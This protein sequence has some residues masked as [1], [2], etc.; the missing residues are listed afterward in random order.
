MVSVTR[1]PGTGRQ[2]NDVRRTAPRLRTALV[3]CAVVALAI[4]AGGAQAAASPWNPVGSYQI[5]FTCTSGCDGT[6]SHTMNISSYNPD[7]GAF[8]GSGHYNGD[9]AK[10]WNVTGTVTG[11]SVTFHIVYDNVFAGYVLDGTGTIASNGT[12]SGSA[13]PSSFGESF[14]WATTSGAATAGDYGMAQLDSSHCSLT[15]QSKNVANVSFR[16]IN[17]YDSGVAGNAW[18]NDTVHRELRIWQVSP[19]M[20]CATITD[21]AKFVTFAGPSPNGTGTVTAGIPGSIRGGEV[22]G[23]FPGTL[24][25][26]PAYPT[27]GNI[28]FDNTFDLHCTAAYTCPGAKPTIDSYVSGYD[29]RLQWWGWQYVTSGHGIWVNSQDGNSGDITG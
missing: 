4:A 15:K 22:T 6:Y 16:M 23:V 3:L 17:D 13:G 27:R 11:S 1:R 29:G 20:F 9:A 26:A 18:A 2:G 28:G 24:N 7:T 19:G 12:M 8:S 25:P 14:T 5:A 21:W 10:S